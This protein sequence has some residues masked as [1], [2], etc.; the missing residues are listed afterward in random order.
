MLITYVCTHT[1]ERDNKDTQ[2]PGD[3]LKKERKDY[4]S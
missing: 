2:S 4:K 1:H 3:F